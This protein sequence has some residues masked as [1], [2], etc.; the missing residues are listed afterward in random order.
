MMP[1]PLSKAA[2]LTIYDKSLQSSTSLL[3]GVSATPRI[4]VPVPVYAR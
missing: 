4:L 2:S 1:A 3:A